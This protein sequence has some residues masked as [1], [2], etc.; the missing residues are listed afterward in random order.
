MA[1]FQLKQFSGIAP[2]LSPRLLNEKFAQTATNIRF[3]SGKLEAARDDY[4]VTTSTQSSS[5][6]AIPTFY[7]YE[8]VVNS[9]ATA[10][11]RTTLT[12]YVPLVSNK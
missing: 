5:H 8:Y 9:T 10:D 3:V 7:P 12:P 6:V 1:Y 4:E 11:Y 2:A